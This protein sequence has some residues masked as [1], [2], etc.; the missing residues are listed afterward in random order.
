MAISTL[1]STISYTITSTLTEVPGTQNISVTGQENM[2]FKTGG[3]A[4]AIDGNLGTG[5]SNPGSVSFEMLYDPSDP[6]HQAMQGDHA[7]GGVSAAI[8]VAIS[9]TGGLWAATATLTKFDISAD[10]HAGWMA[11]V[12][13]ECEEGFTVTDPV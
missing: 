9:A 5:T 13:L 8:T 4:D 2:T 10:K 1:A 12:E 6:V 7:A 3:I 11:Q